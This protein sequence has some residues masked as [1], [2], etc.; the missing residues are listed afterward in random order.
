MAKITTGIIGYPLSHT[1]SPLMHNSVFK[2]YKMDWEYK[3]FETKPAEVGRFMR[4]MKL[5]GLKGI[6]VTVP[7][8]HAVM[9][10]LDK[11]DR[12]ARAIGAVN[13][14]VNVKGKLT[15][16]NT[17]YL[18]FGETLK[19]NGIN[20]K[21]KK[22]LM[23]GAGGAAHA[24]AYAIALHK[25]KIIHIFNIDVPMT[26]RLVKKLRLKNAFINNIEKTADKDTI[27]EESDFIV[28]CTSVG[29]HGKDMPYRID[30][31]KKGIFVY[32]II[33][34]PKCTEFLKRAKARGAKILNG[35]DMLIY[36]GME[37]FKLWTGRKSDYAL[38][39]QKLKRYF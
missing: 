16:F 29:L 10:F 32:D 3:A 8:K 39:K 31:I 37:S 22:V 26:Q 19:K 21:G 11:I 35:L 9:P 23:L 15:G 1:L 34:N 5:D 4:S 20:L 6:N 14:V 18:G 33:Y 25:P 38:I 30:K 7:H 17:D 12:A 13:T 2:K 27:V 36:Q 28:N 24:V